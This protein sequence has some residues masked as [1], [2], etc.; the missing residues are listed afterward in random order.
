MQ[1]T[2]V[3]ATIAAVAAALL[4]CGCSPSADPA[5]APTLESAPSQSE[6]PATPSEDQP[7]SEAIDA[8]RAAQLALESVP[9]AVVELELDREGT[10]LVWEIGVLAADGSGVGLH[11]DSTSGEI[12]DQHSIRLSKE[13]RTAPEQTVDAIIGIAVEAVGGGAVTEAEV[14]TENGSVVWEVTVFDD[15][16]GWDLDIDATTGEVLKQQ[17]D[18]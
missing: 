13:Q 17:Q 7:E 8:A 11:L 10:A 1:K 12:L 9:G 18:S 16:V 6:D 5:S 2:R 3:S 4:L 15:P 14:D